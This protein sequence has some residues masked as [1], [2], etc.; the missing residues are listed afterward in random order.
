MIFRRMSNNQRTNNKSEIVAVVRKRH[1]LTLPGE[2]IDFLG[3]REGDQ[4]VISLVNGSATL[5]PVRRSYAGIAKG[6]Y[7]K[8]FV[9]RERAGW[10]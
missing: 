7:G 9:E 3:L 1:Q 6:L 8:D 10:E 5:R 4:V 2:A